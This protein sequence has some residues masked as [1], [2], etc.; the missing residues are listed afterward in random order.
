MWLD[1]GGRDLSTKPGTSRVIWTWLDL[2]GCQIKRHSLRQ[3]TE[4]RIFVSNLAVLGKIDGNPLTR[5]LTYILYSEPPGQGG[6]A[7]LI[8]GPVAESASV[9][10]HGLT[11]A[12]SDR[13]PRFRPSKGNDYA[14]REP[15]S[16]G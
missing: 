4:D 7:R 14:G 5:F 8:A 1:V 6:I 3:P 15:R 11:R 2:F 12:K 13:L 16:A 9:A 10:K